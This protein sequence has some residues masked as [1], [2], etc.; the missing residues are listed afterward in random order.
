MDTP[1]TVYARFKRQVDITPSGIAVFDSKRTLT[2]HELDQLVDTIVSSLPGRMG[3]IGVVMDH[4]VE[5]IAA[6]LAVLKSGAAYV[7]VEPSFPVDRIRFIM[8][9][10]NVGLILTNPEYSQLLD[11]FPVMPLKRGLAIGHWRGVQSDR[12]TSGKC[13][14]VLYTSGSTGLPKGV[15]VSNRNVCHYADAFHD[16]FHIGAGDVMLQ[17]SV[18]T[19]DIFVE[20]VF[21]TLLSGAALAIA[22]QHIRDNIGELMKFVREYEVS[23]ISGFPYLLLELNKLSCI[24]RS[25]RLL[26][27]GGDVLRAGY[28]DRLLPQV[29]IYNTYGPSE[30]TVCASYFRCNGAM[31]LPDGT[32][33]IGKPVKGVSIEIL[34]TDMEPVSCGTT[35]EICISGDGVSMGYIGNRETEN[36]AFVTMDDG[37]RIYRSGDLGS[38]L[39][40]GTL[41]FHHRMDS[42]VMILGRRVETYEVENVLCQC[43]E[44]ES[45]VVRSATDSN[46]LSYLVAYIVPDRKRQFNLK[47]LKG[48]MRKFLPD[49][50]LPEFFV[51]LHTI[52]LTPNGKVDTQALP[53]ITKTA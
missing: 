53:I 18:C 51:I 40:D 1:T 38:M 22:P 17:Y 30:T 46:G 20:E 15:M 14:Y 25:L 29:E 44:V 19:F 16:E 12:S 3:Y 26:I 10:C 41:L 27:S 36:R 21:A 9:E 8:S 42:Q 2:Y 13:A 4:S 49:Y 37:R 45:G 47:P 7:P 48:R 23:I 28:I 31:A 35:G 50:M 39:A 5:M 24:P 33:P 34:D 32:Y 6:L 11:G 43:P 52:P